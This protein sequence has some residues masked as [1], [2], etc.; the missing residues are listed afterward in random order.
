MDVTQI[1]LTLLTTAFFS[2]LPRIWDYLVTIT[3]DDHKTVI[4]TTHYIEEARQAHTVSAIS[5]AI[6]SIEFHVTWPSVVNGQKTEVL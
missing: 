6:F 1:T 3:R 4:I 2:P 5:T